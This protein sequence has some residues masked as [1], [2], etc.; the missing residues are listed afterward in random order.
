MVDA[1]R[2]DLTWSPTRNSSTRVGRLISDFANEPQVSRLVSNAEILENEAGLE[3][4]SYTDDSEFAQSPREL[5]KSYPNYHSANISDED[6]V[7]EILSVKRTEDILAEG[8]FIYLP[9]ISN[10]EP[11]VDLKTHLEGRKTKVDRYWRLSLNPKKVRASYLQYLFKSDLGKALYAS[12][13]KGRTVPHIS[14]ATLK[15]CQIVYPDLATQDLI[16]DVV[17]KLD[18]LA[19]LS[20]KFKKKVSLNP[21]S[22]S[23]L[24]GKLDDMLS[25]VSQLSEEDQVISILRSGETKTSEFKE[26]FEYNEK[27]ENKRDS[28]LVDACIKT[29][30]AFL[31]S[32]GG[33]LLVG[34]SDD[35]QVISLERDI[36]LNHSSTD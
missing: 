28:R 4:A 17:E 18:R 16:L 22:A 1:Q 11:V 24:V 2:Q 7:L 29:V 9:N 36:T 21:Y 30:A 23:N 6:V 14:L 31:N 33:E 3:L 5:K 26:T 19:S 25:A 34:V 20:N 8:N 35:Q 12:L 15:K 32:D 27:I 13:G 10:M